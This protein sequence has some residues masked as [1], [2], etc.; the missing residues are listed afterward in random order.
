MDR[1]LNIDGEDIVLVEVARNDELALYRFDCDGRIC[2]APINEIKKK[3][4][5]YKMGEFEWGLH[6]FLIEENGVLQMYDPDGEPI[7]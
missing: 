7:S 6:D 2:G 3:F 1:T 4:P 5:K